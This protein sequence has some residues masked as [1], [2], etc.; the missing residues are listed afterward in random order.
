MVGDGI[1]DAP[2]LAQADI[3]IAL[4][5]GTDVSFE[6]GDVVLVHDNPLDVVSSIELG[7]KTVSK[8]HQGFFWALVYNLILLPI[9]AGIFVPFFGLTLRPEYAGLAMALSDICVVGNALLL[10]TFK[11]RVSVGH[12]DSTKTSSNEKFAIDSICKMKVNIDSTHLFSDYAGKRYYF[13]NPHCKEHFDS[14]PLNYI[15]G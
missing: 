15:N 13:C 3:G 5:S 9:A 4:G 12:L 8:I 1:N 14:N 2:A 6:A 7:I 10:G 11:P